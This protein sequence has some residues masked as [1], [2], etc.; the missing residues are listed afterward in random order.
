M[1][2]TLGIENELDRVKDGSGIPCA[3]RVSRVQGYSGQ[4]DPALRVENTGTNE[5]HRIRK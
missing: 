4:P 5:T 2:Y 3:R 1:D